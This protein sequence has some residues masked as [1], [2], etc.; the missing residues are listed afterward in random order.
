MK[1]KG[2]LIIETLMGIMFL[3][4]A[5]TIMLKSIIGGEMSKE[6]RK[7]REE[8]SRVSHSIMNEIKYNY[9]L[10]NLNAVNNIELKYYDNFMIDLLTKDLS[11]MPL[12]NDIKI[13][14]VKTILELD[15]KDLEFINGSEKIEA[16]AQYKIDINLNVGDVGINEN[17]EFYKSLWME[18]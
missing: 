13:T 12:G 17:R 8:L 5:G 16:L 14:K 11:E 15:S 9:T 2:S 1:K 18:M 10:E 3:T 6:V 4:I 7:I